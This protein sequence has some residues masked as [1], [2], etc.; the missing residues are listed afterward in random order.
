MFQDA[1]NAAAEA[2][3][4][5]AERIAAVPGLELHVDGD[6]L[7]YYASGNDDTSPGQARE[8]A[9][10]LI[11]GFCASSG[12]V[13]TIIHTTANG[14][15]KGERYLAATVKPYQ[16]QRVSGRKPKNQPYLQQWLQEYIGARFRSK[17]W[18]EREA[19]D[20]L[21]ACAH[22]ARLS[23]PGY[24]VIATADK[25]M[26]MLP[27][28]HIN[29]LTKQLTRVQ[30]GDYDV[31]GTDS[32]QYGLKWF[33][34]QMLMGDSADNIPGLPK[35]RSINAKGDPTMKL[36]GPKTA[37]ALLEDCTTTKDA[38]QQICDLYALAYHPDIKTYAEVTPEHTVWA[39][40]VVE[41]AA[42]LWMRCD[43]HAHLLDFIQ[44]VGPSIIDWP[45]GIDSAAKRLQERVTLA[46][47]TIN[48]LADCGDPLCTD[49]SS[50]E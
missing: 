14:S 35:Y 22:Y 46:R 43:T 13:R 44:H 45:A 39:D 34:L 2:A 24:I 50:A 3:P 38:A 21:G 28:L 25:D 33:M 16:A 32:K 6:Y 18:V 26:R 1:I 8:N 12:A 19:D 48:Q 37:E 20:G 4:H 30:P 47:N 31:I 29:W 9:I 41:Q 7:A 11:E 5:Q 23:K 40:R 17:V 15:H 49:D 42:L 27:A 36:L 10:S